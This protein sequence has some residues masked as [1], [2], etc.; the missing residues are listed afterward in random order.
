MYR[1]PYNST[2]DQ[3]Q[4]GDHSLWGVKLLVVRPNTYRVYRVRF[5]DDSDE[6]QGAR[7]DP[8]IEKKVAEALWPAIVPYMEQDP[9]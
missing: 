9:Y 3:F 8:K 4:P 7:L 2:P 6:P 1:D 5:N